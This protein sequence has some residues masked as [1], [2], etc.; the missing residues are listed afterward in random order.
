M[1][2]GMSVPQAMSREEWEAI[3]DE[4]HGWAVDLG[5][6][7]PTARDVEAFKRWLARGPAHAQAWS[8]A[9]R[10]WRDMDA[11]ARA[12][13]ARRPRGQSRPRA[14]AGRRLFLG[15][16]VS[17]CGAAAVA[18]VAGPALGLWPSL[19]EMG[20][21]YR[22]RTGEQRELLVGEELRLLMNTQ[23]SISVR[24]ADDGMYRVELVAGELAV[25]VQDHACEVWAGELRVLVAGSD[26]ELSRIGDGQV[27]VACRKGA[28]TVR[29]GS[30]EVA[31]AAFHALTYRDGGW[32]KPVAIEQGSD[33]W[34]QGRVVFHDLPLA[35]VVAEINRYR[36]GRVVLLDDGLARR[37]FSASFA[38]GALDDAIDQL[39]AVHHVR[40]RRVGEVVFLG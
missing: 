13:D 4:A 12:L 31:V 21:D 3:E 19:A 23:T 37:R 14:A 8:R 11:V 29:H 22:T 9:S 34:R 2:S 24:R 32:G 10:A 5:T 7:R 28:A 36:R 1:K 27:R 16:A 20:A 17:A 35:D 38:I 6:G 26:V 18:A 15:A 40:V 25:P 39:Q 33:G 30:R